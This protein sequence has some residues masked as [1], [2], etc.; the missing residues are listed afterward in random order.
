[1]ATMVLKQASVPNR[2]DPITSAQLY[3]LAEAI[4]SRILNGAGDSHWRIPYYIFSAFFRKPRL[5]DGTLYTP[6]TEFFDFYQFVN[7]SEGDIWPT[8]SPQEPEGANLQTNPLNRFIFGMNY[9]TKDENGYWIFEREDFRASI[10]QLNLESPSN[11]RGY[12]FPYFNKIGAISAGG[13]KYTAFGF[14]KEIFSNG[15][16]N[17]NTVNPAGHSYGGY[18]GTAPG[19]GRSSSSS[20]GIKWDEEYGWVNIPVSEV[21]LYKLDGEIDK[22][23]RWTYDYCEETGVYRDSKKPV[24]PQFFI[25]NNSYEYRPMGYIF[26]KNKYHLEQF[27]AGIYL[28][29][30]QK[31]HLYRLIYNYIT[32]A[33]KFDFDWFFRNQYAYAPEIGSFSSATAYYDEYDKVVSVD[34]ININ[35]ET[36]IFSK[37][38]INSSTQP[39]YIQIT[40]LGTSNKP[41][42]DGAQIQRIRLEKTYRL[43]PFYEDILRADTQYKVLD[44]TILHANA[45]YQ[46]GEIFSGQNE[47]FS[48]IDGEGSLAIY[49]P[50]VTTKL[51]IIGKQNILNF[52]YENNLLDIEVAKMP[53]N[54]FIERGNAANGDLYIPKNYTLQ[55]FQINASNLKSYSINLEI[56]GDN[57]S[58]PLLTKNYTFSSSGFQSKVIDWQSAD[59]NTFESMR[60]KLTEFVLE[61]INSTASISIQPTFLFSYKPKI[62]DAYA[63][64][65]AATYWGVDDGNLSNSSH[66]LYSA[67]KLS[68][69]LQTIGYIN[70]TNIATPSEV[71][72]FDAKELNNNAVF[73]TA[74]RLSLFVRIL[75]PNNFLQQEP[76]EDGKS[77]LSFS[78]YARQKFIYGKTQRNKDFVED[79]N[80]QVPYSTYV[81]YNFYTEAERNQNIYLDKTNPDSI[82]ITGGLYNWINNRIGD[83]ILNNTGENFINCY[84]SAKLF[85]FYLFE[86]GKINK[87]LEYDLITSASKDNNDT[88]LSSNNIS[89]TPLRYSINYDALVIN[90]NKINP[91]KFIFYRFENNEGKTFS[92]GAYKFYYPENSITSINI[93]ENNSI[94]ITEADLNSIDLSY[95]SSHPQ[96]GN[97]GGPIIIV[98][99]RRENLSLLSILLGNVVNSVGINYTSRDAYYFSN[100]DNSFVFGASNDFDEFTR[101]SLLECNVS[102]FPK[103]HIGNK[104]NEDKI[105]NKDETSKTLIDSLKY[106]YYLFNGEADYLSYKLFEENYNGFSVPTHVNVKFNLNSAS[107]QG[108]QSVNGVGSLCNLF[109]LILNNFASAGIFLNNQTGFFDTTVKENPFPDGLTSITKDQYNNYLAGYKFS[110]QTEIFGSRSSFDFQNF[111]KEKSLTV[112]NRDFKCSMQV[113]NA[114]DVAISS[115][116]IFDFDEEISLPKFTSSDDYIKFEIAVN[117]LQ[118]PPVYTETNVTGS[119]LTDGNIYI[120][121][122]GVISHNGNTYDASGENNDG[123]AKSIKFI[124]TATSS[125]SV[126][127]GD[128]T[129]A[130]LT[131]TNTPYY[132]PL[133][134]L[135]MIN[136]RYINNNDIVNSVI[137]REGTLS[138]GKKLSIFD[139]GKE[140]TLLRD[141]FQ[142]IAL[143]P[144]EGN[145]NKNGIVEIAPPNGFTNEWALWMNF[146]PYNASDSSPFKEEVY[147]ATGSPFYDRCHLNSSIIPQSKENLH[148]NLGQSLARYVEAPPSYRYMPLLTKRGIVYENTVG[149]S[150]DE[151]TKKLFYESCRGIG[152]PYRIKRVYFK[153]SDYNKVYVVLDRLLDGTTESNSRRSDANGISDWLA[154]GNGF[155]NVNF[156]IGDCSLTNSNGLSGLT[157]ANLN[158]YKGS[159]YPRFF[160]V[161]LLPRPFYDGNNT[162]ELF[163]DKDSSLNHEHIKQAELYIN[164]M[165]EGFANDKLSKD[166]QSDPCDTFLATGAERAVIFSHLTYPDFTYEQLMFQA[167]STSEYYG[168]I[169]PSLLRFSTNYNAPDLDSSIRNSDNPRGFGAIPLVGTYAE[170][171]ATLT[172]A[173][174]LLTE[175]R[176]PN[177]VEYEAIRTDC[178]EVE[179]LNLSNWYEPYQVGNGFFTRDAG[180]YG[181]IA[182]FT[183]PSDPQ[184]NISNCI[185]TTY[186]LRKN[187]GSLQNLGLSMGWSLTHYGPDQPNININNA[188]ILKEKQSARL[189]LTPSDDNL[190]KISYEP[191]ALLVDNA[192]TNIPQTISSSSSAINI[193]SL[194][195]ANVANK[196]SDECGIFFNNGQYILDESKFENPLIC[197]IGQT[198]FSPPSLITGVPYFNLVSF[199][200]CVTQWRLSNGEF[201]TEEIGLANPFAINW[202]PHTFNSSSSIS[203]SLHEKGWTIVTVPTS[204][205]QEAATANY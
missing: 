108:T 57:S 9:E 24:P 140:E 155:G 124:A 193:K 163:N 200:P 39:L 61:D 132:S 76:D 35:S 156:R 190:L 31:N 161:K 66:P 51:S 3:S 93:S 101:K 70:P 112:L 122:G 33:Y 102:S 107:E 117:Y 46:K 118:S 64:L 21:K 34:N 127:S 184:I 13:E 23:Y 67:K 42:Q 2:N 121:R 188:R 5:D 164:A 97:K 158:Q 10:A 185:T 27:N 104:Y 100:K 168:N 11:F 106:N 141:I 26:P 74:R 40:Q 138:L 98:L 171:Y 110:L 150:I 182:N 202:Y 139:D 133:V 89:F 38:N 50:D 7:P 85:D 75:G 86:G 65:R 92:A 194:Q 146:L 54:L 111:I 174:N 178:T 29:R 68:E 154:R 32:Y 55:S 142:D 167:T 41:I 56:Y 144:E 145:N 126:V 197:T 205:S 80:T 119:S 19:S 160:F 181:Y 99:E 4:N 203:V 177:P 169:W 130:L 36:V 62:E 148:L 180:R 82:L 25:T 79:V 147:G 176:I 153:N 44:G 183:S 90:K 152:K 60:F 1:M 94:E 18:Y 125:Y 179:M 159:Y 58:V 103:L 143:L 189:I 16:I 134:F 105:L 131:Q 173:V 53:E 15:Y 149:D 6:E 175:F 47:T 114:S 69:D 201:K 116:I 137:R 14:A 170:S 12:V 83:L 113:F 123:T 17:G 78:R 95:D 30:E 199:R 196:I 88:F 165:R 28:S 109:N 81:R 192:D 73:E 22:P 204:A 151:G 43:E 77:V 59:I 48:I 129:I 52:F 20:C 37:S 84:T 136:Y 135:T 72:A 120:V 8:S 162:T 45:T 187:D 91:E 87:Q 96:F 115:K 157:N 198:N 63:L 191:V 71:H 172:K 49:I 195:D 128:P 166:L 186:N